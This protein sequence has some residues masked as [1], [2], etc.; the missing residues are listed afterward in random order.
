MGSDSL[1][2]LRPIRPSARGRPPVKRA[3][4]PAGASA[5][6]QSMGSAPLPFTCFH[7]IRRVSS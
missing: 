6:A 2:G 4:P 1:R 7:T 3:F 5:T